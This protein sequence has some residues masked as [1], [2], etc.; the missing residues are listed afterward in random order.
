MYGKIGEEFNV[1]AMSQNSPFFPLVAS[2]LCCTLKEHFL[3]TMQAI[4]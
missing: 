4:F 1:C 2:E 3:Q